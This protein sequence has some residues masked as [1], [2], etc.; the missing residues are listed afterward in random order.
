M[1]VII[2]SVTESIESESMGKHTIQ[3]FRCVTYHTCVFD[4]VC[5]G[6]Y[7]LHPGMYLG[8]IW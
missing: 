5:A 6:M 3:Y 7:V 8:N 2:K 4:M 1:R